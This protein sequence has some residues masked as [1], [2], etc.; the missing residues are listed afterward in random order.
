MRPDGSDAART[1]RRDLVRLAAAPRTLPN[2]GAT[3][4][5][6]VVGSVAFEGYYLT[7][8]GG[9]IDEDATCS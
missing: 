4:T 9:Y 2:C 3:T 1:K 6:C 5:V 8:D 7:G